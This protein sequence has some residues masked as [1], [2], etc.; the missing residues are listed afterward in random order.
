MSQVC[1]MFGCM[2]AFLMFLTNC[3]GTEMSPSQYYVSVCWMCWG[4][5]RTTF[6]RMQLNGSVHPL[7][8]GCHAVIDA[9]GQTKELGC[10]CYFN[11]CPLILMYPCPNFINTG[12]Q[13][14][15]YIHCCLVGTEEDM[16]EFSADVVDREEIDWVAHLGRPE[17]QAKHLVFPYTVQILGSILHASLC[18]TAYLAN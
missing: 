11:V 13:S 1:P 15:S 6:P 18:P 7:P 3:H 10:H 8:V 12:T 2:A 4:H 14:Q 5:W 16:S 9:A 17:L